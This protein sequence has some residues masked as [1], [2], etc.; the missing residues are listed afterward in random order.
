MQDV[1]ANGCTVNGTVHILSRLELV[2]SIQTD[3]N[4]SWSVLPPCG[5]FQ[6]LLEALIR[7]LIR[8]FTSVLSFGVTDTFQTH[9]LRL[10]WR[11]VRFE[12][13]PVTMKGRVAE[14]K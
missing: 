4:G 10:K 8:T 5:H 9:W 6:N 7:T 1:Y 11:A 3:S 12:V 2:T 13:D 14:L